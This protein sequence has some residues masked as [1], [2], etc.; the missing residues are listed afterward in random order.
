MLSLPGGRLME[1]RGARL[2]ISDLPCSRSAGLF[3]AA[4]T[5]LISKRV[6]TAGMAWMRSLLVTEGE[7]FNFTLAKVSIDHFSFCVL[8]VWVGLLRLVSVLNQIYTAFTYDALN[9]VTGL[10]LKSVRALSFS[11]LLNQPSVVRHGHVGQT[12]I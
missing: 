6:L 7:P 10:P 8:Y 12:N 9:E 4:T 3:F 1:F 11:H 2:R 5:I